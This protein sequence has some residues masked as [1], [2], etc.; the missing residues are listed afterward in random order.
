MRHKN[1]GAWAPAFFYAEGRIEKQEI[2]KK[3]AQVAAAGGSK[4]KKS[5]KNPPK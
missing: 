5:G 3:S 4:S 2:K 1:T